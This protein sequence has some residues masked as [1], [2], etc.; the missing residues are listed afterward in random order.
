MMTLVFEKLLTKMAKEKNILPTDAQ[1]AAYVPFAKKYQ[2]VAEITIMLPDPYRTEEDWKRDSKLALIR[3]A[4]AKAPLNITDP[5]IKKWYDDHKGQLATPDSY[6]LRVIDCN[7]MD[8]AKKAMEA[9]TKLPFQTVAFTSSDDPRTKQ[10]S[11]DIGTIPQ[12]NLPPAMLAAIKDLKPGEYTKEVLKLSASDIGGQ[13]ANGG[14]PHFMIV[15]MVKKVD[16]SVP[17]FEDAKL[18]VERNVIDQKDHNAF[19]RVA[20]EIED[21]KDKNLSEIKI[22][23]APYTGLMEKKPAPAAGGAQPNAGGGAAAPTAPK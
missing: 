9:L 17:T 10:A 5:E 19:V 20:K 4:L 22:Q 6:Q 14:A 23:L 2:Q 8:K 7:T 1:I 16:G 12:T 3:K 13:A 18:F 15:Q 21:Y 11:G